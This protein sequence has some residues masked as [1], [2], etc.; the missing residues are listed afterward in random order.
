MM[1]CVDYPTA[2]PACG[3]YDAGYP[4]ALADP[5][6]ESWNNCS[7]LSKIVVRAAAAC[8]ACVCACVCVCVCVRACVRVR[9]RCVCVCVFVRLR[10]HPLV[11]LSSDVCRWFVRQP[12]VDVVQCVYE[13]AAYLRCLHLPTTTG[14]CEDSA[15]FP[16]LPTGK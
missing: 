2:P 6:L 12:M 5:P 13:A 16:P 14:A 9:T 3:G 7:A 8:C 1:D 11:A 15:F 4:T 10:D